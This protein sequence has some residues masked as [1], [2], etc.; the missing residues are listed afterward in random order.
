MLVLLLCHAECECEAGSGSGSETEGEVG[1]VIFW[2]VNMDGGMCLRRRGVRGEVE[3][4]VEVDEAMAART[5]ASIVV[6]CFV[7]MRW[8]SIGGVEWRDEECG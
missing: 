4:E 2:L 1:S 5:S 6:G 3:V 8:W 7:E